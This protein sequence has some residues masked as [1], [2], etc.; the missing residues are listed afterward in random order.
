MYDT[1][2]Y[3]HRLICMLLV[4]LPLLG[5]VGCDHDTT[6]V[7]PTESAPDETEHAASENMKNNVT[8][9]VVMAYRDVTTGVSSLR[10]VEAELVRRGKPVELLY[11]NVCR[12]EAQTNTWQR[13]PWHYRA[14]PH[15]FEPIAEPAVSSPGRAF[16]ALAGQP[17]G[18]YWVEWTESDSVETRERLHRE[19]SPHDHLS[20]VQRMSAFLFVGPAACN[21]SGLDPPPPGE[22]AACVPHANSAEARFVPQPETQCRNVR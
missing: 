12:F 11:S 17:L 10:I 18:L 15:R 13:L 6:G 20:D 22:V 19:M 2:K 14:T 21:D 1:D 5:G 8:S 16:L 7:A 3:V 4:A 9:Q